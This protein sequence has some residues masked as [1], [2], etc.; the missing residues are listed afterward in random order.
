MGIGMQITY[1]GLPGIAS[2]EAEAAKQL[3]RLEPYG[4]SL[5]DCQLVIEHLSQRSG[6][7][8]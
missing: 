6:R 2:L 8:L 5:S 4:S 3:L 7:S 1:L